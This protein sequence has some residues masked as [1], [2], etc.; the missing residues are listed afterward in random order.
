MFVSIIRIIG[1]LLTLVSL[2]MC[3]PISAAVVYGEYAVI[4]AFLIPMGL[5]IL[6]ETLLFF[7]TRGYVFKLNTRSGFVVVAVSW[8][9]TCLFGAAPF[10]ISGHIGNFADALFES[11]SGFTTTGATILSSVEHLPRSINLWRMQMHWLGGMGI[12]A[13]T[14]ALLPVLGVGGFQLIK[15]ETTGPEKGKITPKITVTAKILWFIYIA[16]TAVQTVLLMIAGMDF[17]DALGHSFATV[18]TGGF[19]SRNASIGSYRSPGIEWICTIFMILAGINFSLY[20][21]ILVGRGIEF[22]QNTE[23]KVYTFIIFIASLIIVPFIMPLYGSFGSALRSAAFHVASIISTTGFSTADYSLWHPA[24]RMVLFILLFI[25]GC[26]G[27]TAGGIK[28]IRWVIMAKQMGV[29]VKRLLHPHGV[30]SIHLNKRPGRE[31]VVYNV[32]AFMFLYFFMLMLT[33]FAAAINGADLITALTASL[34]LVGNVG[35]GFGKVGP[36]ENFG[37]FSDAAKYWFSFAMLAG[38]LELYTMLVFFMPTY[39]KK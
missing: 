24:A 29:E 38:R 12:V 9:S 19:S 3:I 37:F 32:A 14:V 31:D 23:L 11:V 5:C 39:W 18:G 15:A 7:V 28:V 33:A 4:P 27:S 34:A 22:L 16:L 30:F 1:I 2:T 21:R 25:G 13:L 26:A 6:A 36:A 35:P 10:L 8:I 20:Y 17:F